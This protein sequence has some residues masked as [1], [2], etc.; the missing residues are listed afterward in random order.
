MVCGSGVASNQTRVRVIHW[1][2]RCVVEFRPALLG[3][4]LETETEGWGS[5]DASW[6]R[7]GGL[8]WA[9]ATWCP[10]RKHYFRP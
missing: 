5:C 2:F 7:G 10:G 3:W 1:V 9:H 4:R 8:G 6:K